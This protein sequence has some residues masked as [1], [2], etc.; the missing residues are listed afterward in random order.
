MA[1][2]DVRGI[3]V[4]GQQPGTMV[5]PHD[6]M[7]AEF[8]EHGKCPAGLYYIFGTVGLRARDS[9]HS[10]M[11]GGMWF[12]GA[13]DCGWQDRWGNEYGTSVSFGSDFLVARVF[14][15]GRRGTRRVVAKTHEELARQVVALLP[16]DIIELSRGQA[17]SIAPDITKEA[18]KMAIDQ[19]KHTPLWVG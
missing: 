17:P 15:G 6:G 8:R 16:S 4:V 5:A 19:R 12:I 9:L 14:L 18:R 13:T 2:V 11:G 3:Y 1:I 7:A 10:L